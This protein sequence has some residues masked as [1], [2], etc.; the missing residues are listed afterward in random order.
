V[1]SKGDPRL[2]DIPSARAGHF[3]QDGDGVYAGSYPAEDSEAIAAL[4][5]LR[6]SGAEYLV[7]PHW[8]NWWFD[9]YRGFKQYLDDRSEAVH[10]VPGVCTMFEFEP[11][12]R[13]TAPGDAGV[14]P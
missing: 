8:A 5:R 11:G 9:Y 6:A 14:T 2:L 12:S 13:L 4:D 7:V 3:P 1:I 10:V